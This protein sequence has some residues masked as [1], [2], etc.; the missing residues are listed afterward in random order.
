MHA[1]WDHAH[2]D[3]GAAPPRRAEPAGLAATEADWRQLLEQTPNGHL[4]RENALLDALAAG[5]PVR[6]L[7]LGRSLD[8]VR[9]SGQLLASTGC[10]VGAVYGSPL[11]AL[12]GGALRPHN[13]GTHML[14]SRDHLDSRRG[15]T[16]L[17]VE[18]APGRPGPAKGLD[19]LR[20]G[21]VHLRA[22]Q[23]FR[24]TLTAEEDERV[25]RSVTDRVHTTA[26]LL[27][28]LLRTAAG[29]EGEDRPFVDALAQAVPVV[30]FL[31]Y[32]YFEA[33]AEYLMLHSRSRPTREC[34]EHGELNNHLYKQLAFDAVAGMGTLF[35]LGRFQPGHARL[36]DLVGRIE[37]ALAAGAP[38]YVRRRVAH[39]FATTGLAADQD[40]RDVSFQRISPEHLAAAAPHL[41]G[42]LL[43]REVRLLDRYP[44]LYHVFE[45]AK[46]LEA[47][48]Y[49]N[50]QGICLPF[51]A[52]CGP[53]G[54]VGVN[55]AAP[56][57][58]FTVW[59][60]DLDERGLL[61]P[62]EQLDVV[63]APRL[64]PW[65]VAPLRDRTEEERWI[66]RA[67][68]PA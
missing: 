31:G 47:W 54:E 58:R 44:Q 68:V 38:A 25:T 35:D 14:G 7:H 50:T 3:F 56:D 64:V 23:A 62:V 63:P 4:L 26:A 51:N 45:Q 66:N 43:F 1:D 12:P 49:W 28:R 19:Y 33:V 41:L 2:T 32:V 36:L 29:Q 24:H 61:H 5:A 11:T 59:T 10:L 48:T 52:A 20:L 37:P 53:K 17:V 39:Q 21:A 22:F 46:A 13:L 9:A 34:A 27:D 42:Q 40:V 55:P 6:L 67:P 57:A 30:P 65:L 60:A 18:V 8:Q 16:A 15:S